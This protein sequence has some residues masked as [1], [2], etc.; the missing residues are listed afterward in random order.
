M[1]YKLAIIG[2]MFVSGCVSGMPA[3]KDA[4][5]IRISVEAPARTSFERLVSAAQ[6]LATQACATKQQQATWVV[7]KEVSPTRTSLA[8]ACW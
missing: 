3:E 8:F 1:K 5:L 7:A 6:P 4:E 2:C